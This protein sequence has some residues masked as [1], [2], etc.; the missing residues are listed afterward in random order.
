MK[1]DLFRSNL[2]LYEAKKMGIR[3]KICGINTAYSL[4]LF[5][6]EDYHHLEINS[7]ET[8]QLTLSKL[9]F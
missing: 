9:P 2:F 4:L 3:Y 1:Q 8:L 7:S 6:V 5:F